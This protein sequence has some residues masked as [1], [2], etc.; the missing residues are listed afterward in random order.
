MDAR[1][2]AETKSLQALIP[3]YKLDGGS[4]F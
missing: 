3:T 4:R 1:P 2:V